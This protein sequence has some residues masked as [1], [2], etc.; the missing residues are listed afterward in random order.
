MRYALLSHFDESALA[1]IPPEVL[2][3]QI[4]R[5]IAFTEA[6]A[7]SGVLRDAQQLAPSSAT[8]TVTVRDGERVTHD[9]PY[10]ETKEVFG[11]WWVVEVDDLD[12]ALE[13]AAACPV[14]EHGVVEVRPLLDLG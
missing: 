6:L 8:T 12:T 1:S 11:G 2:Q 7:R 4:G 13:H 9:G 10:A 5:F 3:A 14:S